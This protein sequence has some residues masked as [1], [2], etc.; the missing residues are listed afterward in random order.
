MSRGISHIISN[1][2]DKIYAIINAE[3]E[4]INLIN[5]KIKRKVCCD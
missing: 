1:I 4:G 3:N 2:Q 5:I